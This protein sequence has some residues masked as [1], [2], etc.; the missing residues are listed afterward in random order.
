MK[1]L[2]YTR[3]SLL[4]EKC[5][6]QPGKVSGSPVKW[7]LFILQLKG[8]NPSQL[9][10]SITWCRIPH[11]GD[12]HWG[13]TGLFLLPE[14]ISPARAVLEWGHAVPVLGEAEMGS[15]RVRSEGSA[16]TRRGGP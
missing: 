5:L 7:F 8:K 14:A 15:V 16:G 10:T 2:D 1:A 6:P 9:E 11:R 3:G 12:T 4:A 13:P